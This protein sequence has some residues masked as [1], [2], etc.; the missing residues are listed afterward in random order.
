MCVSLIVFVLGEITDGIVV[1]F[2]F[3]SFHQRLFKTKSST[4]LT[5]HY[6]MACLSLCDFVTTG[7]G[8]LRYT[9]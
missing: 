5:V 6:W 9:Q 8:I 4:S 2:F 1:A 3:N 7:G